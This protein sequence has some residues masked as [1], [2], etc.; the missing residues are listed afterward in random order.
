MRRLFILFTSYLILFQFESRIPQYTIRESFM[1]KSSKLSVIYT[2]GG[3]PIEGFERIEL[4][5]KN[6]KSLVSKLNNLYNVVLI[7]S[8]ANALCFVRLRTSPTTWYLWPGKPTEEIVNQDNVD[9]LPNFGHQT[10]LNKYVTSGFNGLVYDK[11]FVS[12]NFHVPTIKFL[13]NQYIIH[14][15]LLVRTADHYIV[16]YVEEHVSREGHYSKKILIRKNGSSYMNI[17]WSIPNME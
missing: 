1:K 10:F 5:Q 8:T 6:K 14:R 7:S 4:L 16:E 11:V 3:L 13:N 12:D 9:K 2:G 17:S 15:W